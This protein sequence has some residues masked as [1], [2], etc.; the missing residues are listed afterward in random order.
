M[1]PKSEI[2]NSHTIAVLVDNE[3]GVLARVIGL[4]SG[5]CEVDRSRCEAAKSDVENAYAARRAKGTF[6]GCTAYD[7]Y[8][9]LLARSDLDAV[10]IAT[11]DHWH[12]PLAMDA[13]KAGKDIYCEKPISI[14]VNEGRQLEQIVRRTGRIFQTGT[15]Y[16]SIST[17]RQVC[18]F[19]RAGK[20]EPMWIYA[21]DDH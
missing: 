5:V 20:T 3:P 18:G 9:D 12:T 10:V 1:T 14:A 17:I 11:P 7:D 8:H 4:F 6:Q 2:E 13:A 16:R 19:V 15:Q 21:G